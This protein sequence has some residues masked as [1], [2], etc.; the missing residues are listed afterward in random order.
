MAAKKMTLKKFEPMVVDSIPFVVMPKK[1][2]GYY[3][4][5]KMHEIVQ[6]LVAEKT[7]E[8]QEE[9][10]LLR[11]LAET[12]RC[13][14]DGEGFASETFSAFNEYEKLSR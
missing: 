4:A 7:A 6:K 13:H 5:D 1:H 11:K 2:N 12:V 14:R 3:R 10:T 9:L 8:V